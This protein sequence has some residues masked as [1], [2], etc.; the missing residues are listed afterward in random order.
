MASHNQDVW[1]AC[2]GDAMALKEGEPEPD[3]GLDIRIRF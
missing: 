2:C 1:V 3:L